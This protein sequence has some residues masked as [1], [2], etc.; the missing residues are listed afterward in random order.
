MRYEKQIPGH[1]IQV[2]VKFLSLK[3]KAGKE[4]RRFQ[5]AAIDD[6]TCIRALKIYEKH[7]QENA[8]S[9]SRRSFTGIWRIR[10]CTTPT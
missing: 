6:A 5:Y 8:I 3:D 2:D 10:E 4:M 7:T 9:F 1:H